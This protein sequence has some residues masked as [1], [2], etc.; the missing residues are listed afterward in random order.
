MYQ[1]EKSLAYTRK[2]QQ[3]D[4]RIIK[5]GRTMEISTANACYRVIDTHYEMS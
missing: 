5:Y 3:R 1:Y 2:T 4:I